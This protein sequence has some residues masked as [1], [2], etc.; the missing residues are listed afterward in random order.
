MLELHRAH[1]ELEG[2]RAAF[3][4]LI[5]SFSRLT[6]HEL[7]PHQHG[8]IDWAIH[9]RRHADMREPFGIIVNKKSLRFYFRLPKK[10][11]PPL[12]LADVAGFPEK[13]EQ[14][15]GE[16]S[17]R[18]T[19][20]QQAGEVVRLAFPE[21]NF[22][23]TNPDEYDDEQATEYWEGSLKSVRVNA[24]ER[25]GAAREACI[26]KWGYRCAVCD[27]DFQSTYGK[28]GQNFIHVHH[29]KPISEIGAEYQLNP[30]E[31]LRP[32][33]PNCH[34]MLHRFAL[35]LSIE[36]LKTSIRANRGN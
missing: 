5:E 2:V 29:L 32:V 7:R 4:F 25:S 14:K 12:T 22:V 28:R 36:E 10:M 24:Y 13:T 6:D 21:L 31:D 26:R 34:A 1:I 3:D 19:T 18:I 17:V 15:N 35:L 20:V 16:I 27:F 30:E 8:Y 9:L 23:S 33:C 11:T